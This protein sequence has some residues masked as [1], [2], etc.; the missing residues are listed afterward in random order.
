MT[1][2]AGGDD[3]TVHVAVTWSAV[4]VDGRPGCQRR[5]IQIVD[6]GTGEGAALAAVLEAEDGVDDRPAGLVRRPPAKP[7]VVELRPF[8]DPAGVEV[9]GS[10]DG[11]AQPCRRVV[12][13]DFV[14]R[15][16]TRR[17]LDD[18]PE[19][20][21]LHA[22]AATDG[23]GRAVV[24]MGASGAG[25][26]TM[27]AHLVHLGLGL[28]TDEQ[29]AVLGGG[30]VGGFT[31]PIAVKTGGE[32]Y[33]PGDV[34]TRLRSTAP[35]GT[36]THLV[37]PTA[38]GG[39]HRLSGTAALLVVLERAE[40]TGTDDGPGPSEGGS[41][42]S[43]GT[44]VRSTATPVDPAQA[45]ELL[46]AN[47]LDLVRD[48]A[49]RLAHLAALAATTPMVRLGYEHSEAGAL[50]V[51]DL[52]ADAPPAPNVTW[53]VAR[54]VD[55]WPAAT[56]IHPVLRPAPDVF[57]VSLGEE[58]LLFGARSR[59]L[60]RLNQAG[61]AVWDHLPESDGTVPFEQAELVAFLRSHHLVE[62]VD[63]AL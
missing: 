2:A 23:S 22:G 9:V 54:S 36:E 55:A 15:M 4:T 50:T 38:F 46:C 48:P 53:S 61:A 45:M 33:L 17:H 11:V 1:A 7:I 57:T 39:E 31:R 32:A 59:A 16:A 58:R 60:V 28:V 12:L 19:A 24:V 14:L 30:V 62:L 52:L 51:V 5:D 18:H 35:A 49:D 44:T 25:K 8:D 43:S 42:G 40:P 41:G 3:H 26:S 6:R 47:N 37:P 63:P 29:L 20:T 21:H 13:A 27:V 34:G 10:W 56:S